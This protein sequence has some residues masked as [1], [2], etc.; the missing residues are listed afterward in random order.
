VSGS[1][2]H[3]IDRVRPEVLYDRVHE[4][5]RFI[6]GEE[7]HYGYFVP[8]EIDIFSAAQALTQQMITRAAFTAGDRV[9]DVGCGTG[10]QACDLVANH[11]VRVVGITTSEAGVAAGSE[12]AA[13]RGL[14]DATFEVRDGTNNGLESG[15]FDVVW[16]LESSHLMRDRE[17]LLSECARVLAPGGR[18]VL[19]DIIRRREISFAEVRARRS[20]FAVLREA[21]GDAHMLPLDHY[22]ETLTGLGMEIADATDISD[23]TKPTLAAWRANAE[24][25]ADDVIPLI[26]QEGLADF[27][28][29][30][31]VLDALWSDSTLGY[32][33]LSAIKPPNQ[34]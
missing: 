9:L 30:T 16:A 32:G 27:V 3:D 6:M 5:W 25:R 7:F 10:R 2:I 18:L 23:E 14:A 20:E 12:L 33:I 15:S 4:A 22:V 11:G 8:P 21:F 13:A 34:L 24:A 31:K 17:A 26:G 29:A 1:D 19:C 28:E